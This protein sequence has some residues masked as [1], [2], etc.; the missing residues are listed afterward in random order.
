MIP[1]RRIIDQ[2]IFISR[3]MEIVQLR[4]YRQQPGESL[5]FEAIS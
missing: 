2:P 3:A 5:F 1:S 4:A